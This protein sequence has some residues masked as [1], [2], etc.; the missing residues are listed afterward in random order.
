MFKALLNKLIL[1]KTDSSIGTIY[2]QDG[3]I[4]TDEEMNALLKKAIK[5][6]DS[7]VISDD[8]YQEH[9]NKIEQSNVTTIFSDE[10]VYHDGQFISR[11]E[12]QEE[13]EREKY[14]KECDEVL[15]IEHELFLKELEDEEEYWELQEK[16]YQKL[17][18][19]EDI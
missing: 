4:S 3:N 6:Y 11:E 1:R 15:D 12:L 16:K 19:I 2:N 9:L 5:D 14:L 17:K 10:G 13:N 18:N 8:Y 7:N